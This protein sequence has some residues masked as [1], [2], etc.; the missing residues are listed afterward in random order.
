MRWYSGS[1]ENQVPNSRI[2]GFDEIKTL[3]EKKDPE[4]KVI[5]VD[6]REP[7]ELLD[8]GK[9]PGAI[10]I[11]ITS[12]VQSFH[13]SDEDFEDMYGYARPPKDASLVFYCKAGVRAKAAAGLAQHAGWESVGEY[14]GSWLDWDKNK[15]PVEVVKQGKKDN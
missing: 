4:E 3:V 6:V 12:A 15:G 7:Y 9:I 5:L 13:I 10:N 11:P 14:P 8:T 1:A 2:W